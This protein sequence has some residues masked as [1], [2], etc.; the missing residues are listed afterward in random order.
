MEEVVIKFRVDDGLG[1]G[2][3][4]I[5]FALNLACLLR[6]EVVCREEEVWGLNSGD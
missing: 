3:C 5:P 4:E 6:S 2:E 1:E